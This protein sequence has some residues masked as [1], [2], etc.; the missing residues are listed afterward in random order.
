MEWCKATECHKQEY[1]IEIEY[2]DMYVYIFK[3]CIVKIWLNSYIY[4]CVC[5][6][7]LTLS[8][9][10]PPGQTLSH[11]YVSQIRMETL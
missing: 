11:H 6:F 10:H 8:T 5:I 4:I 7:V 9:Y 2:I 1:D 3:I